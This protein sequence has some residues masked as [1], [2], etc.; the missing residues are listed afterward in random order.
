MRKIFWTLIISLLILPLIVHAQEDTKPFTSIEE[1]QTALAGALSDGGEFEALWTRLVD[2]QQIPL[3]IGE[4]AIFLYRGEAARVEW[5]GDF[6]NWKFSVSTQGEQQGDTDLWMLTQEFPSDARL[7]YKIVIDRDNLILDPN[8]PLQQMGS[9]G[10]NSELR[11]PDYVP[12]PYIVYRDD[13][14]HGILTD[15]QLID[16]TS[17][18][19][20]INYR[21]Y[22]PVN[23]SELDN[24]PVIYA[25]D[26][27]DYAND[28]MGSM[29][30]VLDNLIAEGLIEPVMMVFIDP[31]DPED[32]TINR[33]EGEF[34]INPLYGDF[35]ATELVPLI[36][37]LYDTNP[38][39]EARV[40]LGVSF[41]G[42]NAAYV[43]LKHSDV[44]GW[45]AI[46][47]PTFSV[48]PVIFKQFQETDRLPLNIFMTTGCPW[49]TCDDAQRMRDILEEKE[50]PLH[51]IEVHEGHSW[52]NWRALMDDMLIYIF[53]AK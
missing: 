15:N 20:S 32:S 22:Q 52:G 30:I 43:G 9:F 53:G 41:G 31:R 1:F 4:T 17:M 50:Y 47:S 36:D 51:Y 7:D 21:V 34:L 40:M 27:Q 2:N 42:V 10:L 25:T 37:E 23:Y 6:S 29:V 5:R 33:R 13:I 12:S 16:S 28:A 8:N 3:V 19:Y 48:S 18:G 39:P 44:F 38:T 49:D 11:M 24:L 26:G 35:L 46:N 14:E 45:L